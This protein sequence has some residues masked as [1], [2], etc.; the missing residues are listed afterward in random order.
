MKEYLAKEKLGKTISVRLAPRAEAVKISSVPPYSQF[1]YT[2]IV[3]DDNEPDNPQMQWLALSQGGYVNYIYP[4]SGER[5]TLITRPGTEP[6][7]FEA[8]RIV[9]YYRDQAGNEVTQ[10]W[11]PD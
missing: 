3:P 8:Y 11:I 9:V 6:G 2:D 10:E 5:V 7:N 1:A 4:P